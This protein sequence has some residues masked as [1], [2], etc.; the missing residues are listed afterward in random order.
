MT[1]SFP[2]YLTRYLSLPKEKLECQGGDGGIAYLLLGLCHKA[3][4]ALV[5][6]E[7]QSGKTV[8]LALA[9]FGCLSFVFL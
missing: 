6:Q 7:S 1:L 2:N 3:N 8:T 4:L 5:L 9:G